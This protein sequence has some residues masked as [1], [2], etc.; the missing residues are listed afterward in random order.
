MRVLKWTPFFDIKEESPIVPIWISFPNFRLH[1][2]NPKVLHALGL[3]FGRPLQTDQATASRTRPSVA[4][5]LVEVDIS[6]KHPKEIWVGSKAYGYMQQVDFEKIPEF[7]QHC[8]IHGHSVNDCFKLHPNLKKNIKVPNKEGKINGVNQEEIF[9]DDG[10]ISKE[11]AFN[12][13]VVPDTID[14]VN[15]VIRQNKFSVLDNLNEENDVVS[16]VSVKEPDIYVS[17][18]SM[19]HLSKNIIDNVPKQVVALSSDN[20]NCEKEACEEGEF[21]PNPNE[22]LN[23]E[24]EDDM[25]M[26]DKE[27]GMNMEDKEDSLSSSGVGKSSCNE[28]EGEFTKVEKKKKGKFLLPVTPRS[29]RAKTF[30]KP[31]ND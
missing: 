3:I 23:A 24:K 9:S 2:F 13:I 12:T 14:P 28:E 8:K 26:A 6:K 16:N 27:D 21:I 30:S 17:I 10:N 20:E 5:T 25:N 18:E 22:G 4:R 15:I 31:L 11:P 7:C 1:F 29:T 19:L